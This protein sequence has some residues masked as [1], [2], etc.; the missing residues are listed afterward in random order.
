MLLLLLFQST[1]AVH[2][3]RAERQQLLEMCELL[4]ERLHD[5]HVNVASSSTP[6]Q[7]CIRQIKHC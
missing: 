6:Q 1:Q 4:K 2:A 3:M 5:K 7:V